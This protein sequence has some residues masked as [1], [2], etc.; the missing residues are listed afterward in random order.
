M[1]SMAS[2][3]PAGVWG[4]VQVTASQLDS[5][6]ACQ[7]QHG[8]C[9]RAAVWVLACVV[10]RFGMAEEWQPRCIAMHRPETSCT[11]AR[12]AAATCATELQRC[13]LLQKGT[14]SRTSVEQCTP[15]TWR[16]GPVARACEG[17]QQ[18]PKAVVRA[19]VLQQGA[20][21]EALVR[22]FLRIFSME[23]LQAKWRPQAQRP[24]A[25]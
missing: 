20:R 6:C 7:R 8:S 14:Q 3:A 10:L 1:A 16:A 11:A 15:L 23:S 4:H 24:A 25:G 18:G 17:Q 19:A 2:L 21:F 9:T 13:A 22:F 12:G 5:F